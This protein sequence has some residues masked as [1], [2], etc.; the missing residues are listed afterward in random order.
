MRLFGWEFQRSQPIDPRPS[1][2]PPQTDDGAIVVAAGGAFGTYVDLDGTVRTEAELVTKYREMALQP[3]INTAVDE[4]INESMSLDEK[5][6]VEI[7]LDNLENMSPRL[8]DVIRGEFDNCLNILNFRNQAYEI[9]RRWYVDGRLYYHVMIDERHPEAGIQELRYVDPRK[10][11]KVRE[12]AKRTVPGGSDFGQTNIPTT[13]NEYFIFN[14]RGFNY[15]NKVVGPST[16]GLKIAR[17]TILHVTSGLTDTQGTMVLGYLHQAIKA[18][19]QLRTLEDALVIYRLSRAPERRIWYIDV[20]NLPKMK[21]EQYVREIMVKHKNRLIYDSECLALDTRVQLLDGRTLTLNEMIN[22]HEAGKKNWVYSCDPKTG[23]FAPGLVTWAGVTRKNTKVMRL[24]LDNGESIT[25][26]PDHKFPVWDKGFVEAKDLVVGESMIPCYKRIKQISPTSN[27]YEQVFC[28]NK[29]EW[30]FTHREVSRWKDEHKLLNEWTYSKEFAETDKQT[31]HHK[32]YN[33]FD[34]TPEN[35]TRMNRDDHFAYHKQHNSLAGKI[36]G[37]VSADK[38]RALGIDHFNMSH[39]QR[40]ELSRSNG[41]KWAAKRRELGILPFSGK[42]EDFKV[43]S[44]LGNERLIELLKDPQYLKTYSDKIKA[45]WTEEVR[46]AASERGKTLEKAHFSKM[47]QIGNANRWENNEALET[48]S[49]RQ[50]T[51]YTDEILTLVE[52][53][54]QHGL[55]IEEAV[56]AIEATADKNTWNELNKDQRIKQRSDGLVFTY[57][58]LLRI[59]KAEGY[60]DWRAY[61][62]QYETIEREANGRKRR[63]MCDKFSPEWRAKLSEAAKNRDSSTRL[64]HKI[65]KIEFLDETM[66]TGTLTIDGD[67]LYHNYHTFA[68]DAGIYTKNSGQVRDDRKFMTM[69]E[70]YWLPRRE[71][72]RGTEVTTLPGGQN[73]GQMEDVL[74]FQKKLYQTLYVP[75]NRLNS[76]AL[77]S[78][79]RATEVTRDEIKFSRFVSR[80]RYRFSQLFTKMLEKQLSLKQIMTVEEF[81][82]VGPELVYD[83][84]RD[85]YFTELKDT[86]MAMSRMNA[87]RQAQDMVGKYYS[88]SWLRKTILQQSDDDIEQMDKE[89]NDEFETGDVRWQNPLSLQ[90]TMLQPPEP[91]AGPEPGSDEFE[92]QAKEH[93]KLKKIQEAKARYDLLKKKKNKSLA[94]VAELHSV[95]QI[96][97]KNA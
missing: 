37:K 34:N 64:N 88:Q 94:D 53:C 28:N 92:E 96:T 67:E 15:G 97:A 2:A 3:E 78:M 38:R 65:I 49:K 45:G 47:G 60:K 14:D 58:D 36:G 77:F 8:K 51:L 91:S 32:N 69:L 62:K 29:K 52:L 80:L 71:G 75:V 56:E 72:G 18:I 82:M 95:A 17:D 33:R 57:K 54:A 39:E 41:L 26:T 87:A 85:N 66:D 50:T 46:T 43:S 31:I 30:S 7:N 48:H 35:L 25:C 89:I 84:S 93:A 12:I 11:R 61:R 20:G 24:T 1:F 42:I 13:Q 90:Q 9:Y 86:E 74:Y 83:F 68:L 40:I 6:I 55:K 19:N 4:I 10:I 70:D 44:K 73:L 59:C 21:A 22:E 81:A 27:E 63:S 76:D 16:A 79:G 23:A 5:D